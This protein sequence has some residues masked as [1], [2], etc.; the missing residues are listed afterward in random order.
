ML[1][2]VLFFCSCRKNDVCEPVIKPAGNLIRIQQGV[3]PDISKDTVHLISYESPGRIKMVVD[4]ARKDTMYAIYDGSG[5]LSRIRQM[6]DFSYS[7]LNRTGDSVRLSYNTDGSLATYDY[8]KAGS[9]F[10]CAFEYAGG[11]LAKSSFYTSDFNSGPL[12]LWRTFIY[13]M[14][15]GN[16]VG[17][18]EYT[19]SNSLVEET[20]FTYGPQANPFKSIALFNF[21]NQ[22]GTQEVIDLELYFNQN[23]LTGYTNPMRSLNNTNSFNASQKPD[24]I[25]SRFV[26]PNGTK[27][28]YVFTRFFSY[29]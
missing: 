23:I 3:D 14:S 2:L 10:Q 22:L 29:D 1:P 7:P 9:Q 18:K 24:K 28:N 19:A 20:K 16:M 12:T 27:F 8:S 6:H 26:Y 21:A 17:R 4:S 13:E 11:V 15:G 5:R 25:V